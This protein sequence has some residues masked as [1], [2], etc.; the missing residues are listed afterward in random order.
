MM[1]KVGCIGVK[2][3]KWQFLKVKCKRFIVFIYCEI[4]LN[5]V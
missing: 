2:F 5:I 1:V 3:K 4:K